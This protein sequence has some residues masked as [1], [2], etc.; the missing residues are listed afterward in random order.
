MCAALSV[1]TNSPGAALQLSFRVMSANSTLWL[2]RSTIA[3]RRLNRCGTLT[4]IFL[5]LRSRTKISGVKKLIAGSQ[6]ISVILNNTAT[7]QKLWKQVFFQLSLNT[8]S[9]AFFIH[10]SICIHR[11]LIWFATMGWDCWIMWL[12]AFGNR[13]MWWEESTTPS[14]PIWC[15]PFFEQACPKAGCAVS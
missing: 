8:C 2:G 7:A 6:N 15:P 4:A 14:D 9:E 1:D 12:S 5:L 10:T 11:Y 13:K 3:L